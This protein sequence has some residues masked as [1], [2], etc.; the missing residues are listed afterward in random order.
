MN[1]ALPCLALCLALASPLGAQTVGDMVTVDVLPGWRTEAGTHMAAI[2]VM[3]APGW[4]TYWRAPG[5]A[6]IPAQF[7]WAGS[8]NV[9]K[10]ALH[11]PVPAVF[12]QNGLTSVGYHDQLILPI[13]LTPRRVGQPIALSAHIDMG[14]CDDVCVPVSVTV[15]AALAP[16]AARP[17]ARIRAALGDRPMTAREAGV[18][19]MTCTVAPARRGLSVTA[20]FDMPSLGGAE[21]AVIELPGAPVWVSE[22]ETLRNGDSLSATADIVPAH[23]TTL[24]LD[25]SRLR[26][27][28]LGQRGAVDIRGCG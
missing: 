3:L 27:T 25:R 20:A 19:G 7:D 11:W 8:D 12:H 17:D 16:E 18:S 5:D 28:V 2:R 1:N 6:G 26:I 9:G 10:V 13:E 14:V 23:G 15:T 24:A 22:A 4:K 21:F